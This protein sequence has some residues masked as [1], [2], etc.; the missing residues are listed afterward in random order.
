MSL[1]PLQL[2]WL[3]VTETKFTLAGKVSPI[4]TFDAKK[5]PLLNTP[6]E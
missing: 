2:P 3:G 5:G 1:V 6:M 4:V